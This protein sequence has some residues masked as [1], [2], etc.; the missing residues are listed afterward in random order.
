[1]NE[2]TD[3]ERQTLYDIAEMVKDREDRIEFFEA[4][5]RQGVM[6]LDLNLVGLTIMLWIM[7]GGGLLTGWLLWGM[8]R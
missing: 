4:N 3:G 5:E 8:A 2:F 6:I 7:F 1:M